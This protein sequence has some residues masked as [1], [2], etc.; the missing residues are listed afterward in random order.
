MTPEAI[1]WLWVT[2]AGAAIVAFVTWIVRYIMKERE[3]ALD[4]LREKEISAIV[5]AKLDAVVKQHESLRIRVDNICNDLR[6]MAIKKLT[7]VDDKES[8]K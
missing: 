8:A 3:E 5:E 4:A 6:A 1:G 7:K 2:I